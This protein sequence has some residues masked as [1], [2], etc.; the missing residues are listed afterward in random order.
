MHMVRP[1]EKYK[2]LTNW[3]SSKLIFLA[4]QKPREGGIERQG[5]HVEKTVANHTSNK[6]LVSR[7]YKDPQTQQ[8]TGHKQPNYKMGKKH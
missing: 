8:L 2:K 3:T 7:I 4:L 6:E 5:P 1:T